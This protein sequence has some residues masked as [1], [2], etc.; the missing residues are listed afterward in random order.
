M[1]RKTNGR[2]LSLVAFRD[3]LNDCSL[4]E[5]VCKGHAYTCVNNREG[6]DYVKEKLDRVVCNL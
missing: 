2:E 1:G 4:M 6:A 3:C 5:V